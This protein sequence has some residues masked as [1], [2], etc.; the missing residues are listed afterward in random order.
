MNR[1]FSSSVSYLALLAAA[2][3]LSV[4]FTARADSFTV[5]TG[6]TQTGQQT[7]SGTDIGQIEA[8]G[9]L[10]VPGSA[11]IWNG[12]ATGPAGVS[13]VN[14]GNII[15]GSRAIDTSGTVSGP[16]TLRNDGSIES[17]NDTLRI[18]N[19]FNNGNLHVVNTSSMTSNTGQV[20]DL[21]GATSATATVLIENAG[22]ITALENDAIRFGAGTITLINSGTIEAQDGNRALSFDDD[23]NVE[24]LKS[25]ELVNQLGG[26]ILG[27]DDAFKISAD[28]NGSSAVISIGNHGLIDGG[29][30][31]ALDFA[32]LTSPD[33]VI[34]V[35]NH[36]TG[37]IQ[38]QSADAMRPGAGATV[39]NYGL[40]QSVDL[41][42]DGD[43]VDFQDAGGTVVNK[44]GGQILGA[45]HGITGDGEMN[46]DNEAGGLIVGRNGSGINIDSSGDT[47]VTVTNH[48]AIRGAVTGLLDDDGDPAVPDGD[49]DGVD[50]DGQVALD[51][52]GL[53]QGTG[54]TGTK[55]GDLNTADGIAAGAAA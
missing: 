37:I 15:S 38:S 47:V 5:V 30:G 7:V 11:I 3:V 4:P 35:T 31:Q 14:D 49:G 26:K 41:T 27:T 51:N 8:G 53:I 43:G 17:A 20:F 29:E 54:A 2:T 9:T 42:S 24:T 6:T 55:D 52:Y 32:D 44:A 13:I 18:N 1:F 36:A 34:T 40:I 45:K 46:V 39:T 33:N 48:G 10:D 19:A 50:V 12:A 25:F 21:N 23:G 28:N 16:F 22:T